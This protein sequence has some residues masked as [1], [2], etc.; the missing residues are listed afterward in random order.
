M[1]DVYEIVAGLGL[2]PGAGK[3]GLV[4]LKTEVRKEQQPAGEKEKTGGKSVV[5]G[6][7]DMGEPIH[8]VFAR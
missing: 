8:E 7:S 4:I 3:K 5:P 6:I 2:K 1:P